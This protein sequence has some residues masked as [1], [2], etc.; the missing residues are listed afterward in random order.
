VVVFRDRYKD[1]RGSVYVLMKSMCF[2][3]RISCNCPVGIKD[4]LCKH[5]MLLMEAQKLIDPLPPKLEPAKKRGRQ[6]KVP[7]ALMRETVA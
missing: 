6:K 1:L 7:P 3:D 4:D 5:A 2:P